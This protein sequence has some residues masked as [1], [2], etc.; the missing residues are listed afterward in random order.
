MSWAAHRERAAAGR[1][2]KGDERRAAHAAQRAILWDQFL[3]AWLHKFKNRKVFAHELC[4][5]FSSLYKI[6]IDSIGLGKLLHNSKSDYF[7]VIRG[8]RLG[9]AI[10]WRVLQCAPE[11][12]TISQIDPWEQKRLDNLRKITEAEEASKQ[13]ARR[14]Y[15]RK[16]EQDAKAACFQVG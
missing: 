1:K 3:A 10:R 7:D 15:A 11:P 5:T 12:E 13:L 6:D 16:L 8:K 2:R 9:G 14:A 4:E